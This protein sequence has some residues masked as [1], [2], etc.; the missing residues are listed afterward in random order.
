MSFGRKPVCSL[1]AINNLLIPL[2]SEKVK[3]MER[4]KTHKHELFLQ[5]TLQ[6]S[7]PIPDKLIRIK[8]QLYRPNPSSSQAIMGNVDPAGMTEEAKDWL[9]QSE[10]S[11]N[12]DNAFWTKKA[13]S[14]YDRMWNDKSISN[15]SFAADETIHDS[16]QQFRKGR[17]S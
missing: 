6:K 5:K 10:N 8:N 14:K 1:S 16:R 12:A 4:Q 7:T 13:P 9:R 17:I 3:E 2:D 15:E 11:E